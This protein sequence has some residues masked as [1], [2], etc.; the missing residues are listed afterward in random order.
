MVELGGSFSVRLLELIKCFQVKGFVVDYSS[1]GL[2]ITRELF[3][4]NNCT[5]E[6]IQADFLAWPHDGLSFDF[7]VHWGVAEHFDDLQDF[8]RVSKSLLS[9]CGKVVFTMPN[10]EAL[11]SSAWKRWAPDNWSKH[12]YHSVDAIE[13][14][15]SLAG[16]CLVDHGY[17]GPPIVKFVPWEIEGVWQTMLTLVQ[18]VLT[19]ARHLYPF[20]LVGSRWFSGQRWFIAEASALR[21]GTQGS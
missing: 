15:C 1:V 20:Y 8:L 16:L 21:E 14:A 11:G 10:M 9:P 2:E 7:V 3:A 18:H 5:V 17:C 13:K 4:V 19:K 6:T 12:V